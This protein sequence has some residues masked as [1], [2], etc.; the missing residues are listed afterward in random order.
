[1][2]ENN[3]FVIYQNQKGA[4]VYTMLSIM[5]T[6]VC[7]TGFMV[8]FSK[9]NT[10][11]YMASFLTSNII[12]TIIFKLI[13]LFGT[14]FMGYGA[15]YFA[16]R[17]KRKKPILVV[18]DKGITDHTSAI[19]VG[20]IPWDDIERIY[21]GSQ[22]G[23][24]FIELQIKDEEKYLSNMSFIKKKT[25]MANKKLGHQIVLITLNSTG[26]APE[27]IMPEIMYRFQNQ[28]R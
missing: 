18:N 6:A 22:Q 26:I 9:L 20:F 8:D 24:K 10:D 25:V 15:V 21:I 27:S 2:I 14:I 11:Y 23:N 4:V 3:E 28:K 1:M 19:S 13:L 7:F 12:I 16:K 5:M 17:I